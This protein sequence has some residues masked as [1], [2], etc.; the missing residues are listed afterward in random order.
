[1]F[2]VMMLRNKQVICHG[3][4]SL[5]FMAYAKRSRLKKRDPYCHVEIVESRPDPTQPDPTQSRSGTPVPDPTIKKATRSRSPF[6]CSYS[7]F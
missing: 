3:G 1:M 2:Y 6:S 4:F 5:E 7:V